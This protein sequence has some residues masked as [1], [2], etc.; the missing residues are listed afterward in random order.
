M[1]NRPVNWLIRIGWQFGKDVG[2]VGFDDTEWAPLLGPGL[3]AIAQPTDDLGRVAAT[4]LIERLR[5]L[6]MPPR[7]ILLAGRLVPRGSSRP[8]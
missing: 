6:V 1:H 7:Q 3:T 5:G 4:C 2:L 8:G